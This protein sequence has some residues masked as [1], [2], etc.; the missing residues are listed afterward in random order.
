[1]QWIPKPTVRLLYSSASVIDEAHLL[2]LPF[3]FSVIR[4]ALN[5]CETALKRR[6]C[7][8]LLGTNYQASLLKYIDKENLP[9]YL[10]GMSKATLLDD[11]GPWKDQKVI[12][13]INADYR[14]VTSHDLE[15]GPPPT[16]PTPPPTCPSRGKAAMK[17]SN[18]HT[19]IQESIPATL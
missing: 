14:A 15:A 6:S 7:L 10:G 18:V 17:D 4:C 2:E 19:Y 1:M 3:S 12:D 5:R 9:E 8:Q 11:V 13:E 16:L